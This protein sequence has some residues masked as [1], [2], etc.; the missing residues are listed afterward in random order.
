MS[1][2]QNYGQCV[3]EAPRI[4]HL[5]DDDKLEHLAEANDDERDQVESAVD[6]C[7]MQAIRIV[8]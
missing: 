1:L 6:V 8:D 4:F 2:C 3:F 5:N 7:P